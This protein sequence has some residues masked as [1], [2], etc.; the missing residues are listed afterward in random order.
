M[1]IMHIRTLLA[2]IEIFLEINIYFGTIKRA[3]V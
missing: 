2:G 1:F 3:V